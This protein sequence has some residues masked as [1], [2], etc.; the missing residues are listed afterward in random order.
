MLAQMLQTGSK[1]W[2][3]GLDEVMKQINNSPHESLP[4]GVTPN[5]VM[6]GRKQRLEAREPPATR[7]IVMAI[8]EEMINRVCST[9]HPNINEN[10]VGA[11]EIALEFNI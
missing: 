11:V 7:G 5:H 3:L 4:T 10:D 2:S 6:F 1:A 8:S 9:D